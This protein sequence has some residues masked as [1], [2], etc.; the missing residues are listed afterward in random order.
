MFTKTMIALC[1]AVVLAAAFA[2]PA[3]AQTNSAE[4]QRAY[5]QRTEK[6]RCIHGDE[7]TTSAY[8]SW[9]VC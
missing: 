3:Q 9:M 1:G 2:S 4:W 7:S 8:P 5:Q 6:G